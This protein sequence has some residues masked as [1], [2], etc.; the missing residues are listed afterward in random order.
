MAKNV[1]KAFE[2]D[3]KK[4]VP[5]YCLLIRLPDPPHS[6]TKRS[7][8]RF[9]VKNPCDYICYDS[10][11]RLLYC[12]ELKTTSSKSM[13]FENIHSDEKDNKMIHRH[14]TKAL[15]EFSK[16]EGVIAGFVFNFRHF[17][18]EPNYNEMTYF[19]EAND[20][21]RMCDSINKKSFNEIDA[22]L[23]GAR[24]IDGK[25]KRTRFSWDVDGLLKSQRDNK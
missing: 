16:Y 15:L 17:E 4:S 18:G 10:E 5:D 2:A 8:T 14:Q 25:K 7:D 20:F 21:Q 1:G 19:M 11:S 24:R 22:V 13:S 6:F 9:S 3:W 23:Y 12:L